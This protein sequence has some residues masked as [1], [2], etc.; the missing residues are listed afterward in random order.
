LEAVEAGAGARSADKRCASRRRVTVA[1]LTATALITAVVATGCSGSP[2]ERLEIRLD[3]VPVEVVVAE[4]AAER[5]RGLQGSDPLGDGEGMLFV[6]EESGSRTFAMKDVSFPIDVIFFDESLQVS[7][8]EPLDPGD[9][10]RVTSPGP[11][12]Y[13]LETA[14]GWADEAGISIGDTLDVGELVDEGQ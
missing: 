14:Q 13:V 4:T 5:L 6:W 1:R 9:T 3:G 10:R 8:I 12:P 11:A 2:E 7:A